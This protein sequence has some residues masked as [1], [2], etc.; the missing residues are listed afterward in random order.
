MKS[1]IINI[2]IGKIFIKH[3]VVRT[4]IG[5]TQEER[6][7]KQDIVI[8]V[9]LWLDMSDAANTDNIDSTISYS[10]LGKKILQYTDTN[11]FNLLEALAN[12]I[13]DICLEDGRV[14]K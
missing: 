7:A 4:Y 6:A 3:L 14:D 8:N 12:A 9:T 13:A 11:S 10:T 1:D 5:I 2:M